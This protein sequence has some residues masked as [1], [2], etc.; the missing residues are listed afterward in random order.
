MKY[1]IRSDAIQ[2]TFG[3]D[4]H[5]TPP[6]LPDYRLTS[7]IACIILIVKGLTGIYNKL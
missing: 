6:T 4:P 1:N 3:T 7:E 5:T 2:G